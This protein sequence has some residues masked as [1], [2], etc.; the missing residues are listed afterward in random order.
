MRHQ[1]PIILLSVEPKNRI[2]STKSTKDT[3]DTK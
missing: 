3:K 1:S 2:K